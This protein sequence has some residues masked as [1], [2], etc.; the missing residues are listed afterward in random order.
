MQKPSQLTV[1]GVIQIF[2][3]L[4][5]ICGMS[6]ISYL[7]FTTVC[8]GLTALVSLGTCPIGALCGYAACFLIPIGIVEVVSGI[9]T[10]VGAPSNAAFARYVAW[11]EIASLFVGGGL[12]FIAGCIGV[13]LTGND[14]VKAWIAQGS[15]PRP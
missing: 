11:G 9:L 12:S 3:G 6:A 1:V 2:S 15:L 5:N 4:F 13:M 7:G 8:G 10:L 14:E